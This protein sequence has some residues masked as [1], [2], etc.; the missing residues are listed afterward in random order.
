MIQVALIFVITLLGGTLF[1]WW[2]PA[3]P[4]FLAGFWKPA[5]PARGFLLAV[6][7]GG[8]AWAAAAL[9]FDTRNEGLLSTRIAALFHLPGSAG[10]ILATALMGGITAGLGSLFGARFRRFWAS[11]HEALAEVDAPVPED[12][13]G[14]P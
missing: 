7:A 1:P 4:G 10:L 9:W 3:V 13:A 5:H 6:L 2:W 14:S 11:L 8:L 12:D